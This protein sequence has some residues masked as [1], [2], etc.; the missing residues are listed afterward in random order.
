MKPARA[1][2]DL[3]PETKPK[4]RLPR[5]LMHVIDA[6]DSGCAS[7]TDVGGIARFQCKRCGTKTEWI[8]YRT[9]TEAKRGIPCDHCN[10]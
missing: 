4:R 2:I 6:G 8:T 5:N 3:F 10:P 1:Q 7:D 9:V